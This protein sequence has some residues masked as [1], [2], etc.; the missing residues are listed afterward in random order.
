[1]VSKRLRALAEKTIYTNL[2]LD[3]CSHQQLFGTLLLHP[4]LSEKVNTM[5]VHASNYYYHHYHTGLFFGYSKNHYYRRLYRWTSDSFPWWVTERYSQRWE[6]LHRQDNPQFPIDHAL[7]EVTCLGTILSLYPKL[8]ELTIE[9]EG[10]Y[11]RWSNVLLPLIDNLNYRFCGGLQKLERLTVTGPWAYCSASGV[12]GTGRSF[13]KTLF[14]LFKLPALKYLSIWNVK[15]TASTAFDFPSGYVHSGEYAPLEELVFDDC[16]LRANSLRGILAQV[17]SNDRALSPGLKILRIKSPEHYT[18]TWDDEYDFDVPWKTITYNLDPV[19]TTLEALELNASYIDWELVP[20]FPVWDDDTKPDDD[21]EPEDIRPR[22]PEIQPITPL[23]NFP[24]LKILH[25]P[26]RALLRDDSHNASINHLLPPNIESLCLM[27]D[28]TPGPHRHIF[29]SLGFL[30]TLLKGARYTF[31]HLRHVRLIGRDKGG[32]WEKRAEYE[33]KGYNE[34]VRVSFDVWK[35]GRSY[36]P[37]YIGTREYPRT[38]I[39]GGKVREE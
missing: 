6:A 1:M 29:Y 27:D 15:V 5:H 20:E 13:H 14:A 33:Q 10:E 9:Y 16:I 7:N 8:T 4:G 17:Q 26:H 38:W 28:N 18:S 34:G 36:F 31:P 30:D 23:I 3:L 21:T 11:K 19:R 37:H 2:E 32:E 39:S 22:Y 35:D 12:L 25:L 24:A